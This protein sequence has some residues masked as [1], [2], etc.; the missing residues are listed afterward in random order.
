MQ[1]NR[2][3]KRTAALVSAFV[4]IALLVALGASAASAEWLVA[5]SALTSNASLEKNPP[6]TG[7]TTFTVATSPVVK[8]KCLEASGLEIGESVISPASEGRDGLFN[9]LSYG[10]CEVLEPTNCS[11]VSPKLK[12]SSLKWSVSA[13][14]TV[15][16]VT[17]SPLSGTLLFETSLTGLGCLVS[18]V[19]ASGSIVG[20]LVEG[21]VE[22]PAHALKFKS[23]SGGTLSGAEGKAQLELMSHKNWS[24]H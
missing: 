6:M 9:W 21:T 19:L 5:G 20:E 24:W 4:V 11:L 23:A 8:I 1:T 13:G 16:E 18:T 10:K 3:S 17:L 14:L 15:V 7:A 2:C 12:T 22:L